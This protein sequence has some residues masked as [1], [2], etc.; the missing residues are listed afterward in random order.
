[1]DLC[2]DNR[3][4]RKINP[5]TQLILEITAITHDIACPL[6]R[7]KYGNTNGKYQEQEGVILVEEF[8]KEFSL[9]KNQIKRIVYLV[10]HHHTLTNIKGLNYQILIWADYIVNS[11]EMGYSKENIEHFI[12]KIVKTQSAKIILENLI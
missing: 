10:G 4:I 2:K 3:S 9:S 8:L 6:C 5:D 11:E 1:M 7:Q 12:D